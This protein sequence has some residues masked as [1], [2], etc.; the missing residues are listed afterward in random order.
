MNQVKFF[1]GCLPQDLFIYL[2]IYCYFHAIRQFD[3]VFGRL[4]CKYYFCFSFQFAF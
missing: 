2:F 3:L 4:V 1:K